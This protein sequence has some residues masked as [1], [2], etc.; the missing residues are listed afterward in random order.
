MKEIHIL[1]YY[2]KGLQLEQIAATQ[3]DGIATM[4]EPNL[5]I[6]NIYCIENSMMKRYCTTMVVF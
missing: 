2:E 3:V 1:I 6:L 5:L 4:A